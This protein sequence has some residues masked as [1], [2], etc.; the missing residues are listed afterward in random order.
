MVE[1]ETHV[2]IKC[3]RSENGGYFTSNE[4]SEFCE[5]R[6]IKRQFSASKTPQHNDIVERKNRTAQEVAK[7]MLNE[8][9]L[10]DA[11]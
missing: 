4:F 9:K 6:G 2:K 1:K 5:T 7:T 3:L 8:E 11:Y 10:S